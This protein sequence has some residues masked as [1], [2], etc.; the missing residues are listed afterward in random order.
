MNMSS[1]GSMKLDAR[2]IGSRHGDA[3]FAVALALREADKAPRLGPRAQMFGGAPG[4]RRLI[5]PRSFV[6]GYGGQLT[7][8]KDP[9]R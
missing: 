9:R 6:S 8:L 2:R 7:A 1:D 4:F 3:S 5:Q